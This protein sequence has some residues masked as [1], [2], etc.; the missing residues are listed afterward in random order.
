[1]AISE[2][3]PSSAVS[4]TVLLQ[5][6]GAA[7][8]ALSVSYSVTDEEGT[9]VVLTQAIESFVANSP[10]VQIIIPA[11][12]NA[13]PPGKHSAAR[14][15]DVYA[16]T[17]EGV[18]AIKHTYIIGTSLGLSTG[19][20]SFLAYGEAVLIASQM[21]GMHEFL[22][23][24]FD[25][26]QRYLIAAHASIGRLKVAT[27]FS[28]PLNELDVDKLSRLDPA[29]MLALKKAQVVEANHLMTVGDE[30]SLRD[31]GVISIAVDKSKN[32]YMPI[33]PLNLPTSKETARLLGKWIDYSVKMGRV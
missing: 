17:A 18:V 4:L 22:N 9:P 23:A 19:F 27:Q 14:V 2:F 24:T 30:A 11:E 16:V 5:K 26:Q 13:L 12:S 33:K 20:N 1:M 32:T 7:I 10:N 28:V 29:L 8:N 3:A 21:I 15:V 6:N 25:D 31:D